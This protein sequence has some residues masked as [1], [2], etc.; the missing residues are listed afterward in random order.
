MVTLTIAVKIL[1][2]HIETK[3]LKNSSK[4]LNINSI[5]KKKLELKKTVYKLKNKIL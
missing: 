5:F 4:I 3:V 2:K 1:I